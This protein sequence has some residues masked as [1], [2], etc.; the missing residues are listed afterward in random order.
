MVDF[1]VTGHKAPP[2]PNNRVNQIP[3]KI[4][5]NQAFKSENQSMPE[6]TGM[7]T[8]PA[9]SLYGISP[10][11]LAAEPGGIRLHPRR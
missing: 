7:Q 2:I 4:Y 3:I 9:G 11:N 1:P 5:W 6:S 8:G 10:A